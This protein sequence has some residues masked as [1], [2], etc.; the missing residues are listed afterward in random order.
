MG[1]VGALVS[2]GQLESAV[3]SKGR[4]PEAVPGAWQDAGRPARGCSAVPCG[5]GEGAGGGSFPGGAFSTCPVQTRRPEQHPTPHR[6][7]TPRTADTSE[8][9]EVSRLTASTLVADETRHG[10]LR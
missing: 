7:F 5:A 1:G 6:Q 9:T 8:A 2:P 4:V 10:E 3:V